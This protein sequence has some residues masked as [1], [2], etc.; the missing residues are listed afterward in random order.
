[1]L[2]VGLREGQRLAGGDEQLRAHQIQARDRFRDRML[3]LQPRVHF[4]EIEPRVVALAF[5]QE[6]DGAGVDVADGAAGGDAR[7]Q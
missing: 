2:N 1:M 5:E 3:D 4:E 6:L 7:R